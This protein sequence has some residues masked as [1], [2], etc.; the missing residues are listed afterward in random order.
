MS[1]RVLV[2][3]R[4][5][6]FLEPLSTALR[7]ADLEAAA[8]GTGQEALATL[9]ALSPVGVVVDLMTLDTEATQLCEQIRSRENTSA[10][11][12]LFVGTGAE[13]IRST[14]DALIAGGDGFFQ[15]PLEAHR[16]VAKIAAYVGVPVPAVDDALMLTDGSDGGNAPEPTKVGLPA[17][18]AL[19]DVSHVSDHHILLRSD[20][21]PGAP[22]TPPTTRRRAIED[23]DGDGDG[24]GQGD[25]DESSSRALTAPVPSQDVLPDTDPKRGRDNPQSEEGSFSGE[26]TASLR[27]GGF[28][29]NTAAAEP[30][31]VSLPGHPTEDQPE[32]VISSLIS[33]G[34]DSAEGEATSDEIQR[35]RRAGS[36]ERRRREYEER[37]RI[38]ALER[39]RKDAE[40]RLKHAEAEARR[41]EVEEQARIEVLEK[42]RQEAEGRART[43]EEERNKKEREEQARIETLERARKDA[44]RKAQQAEEE[45][46]R[47]EREEQS[48]IAVLERARQEAEHQA[49]AAAERAAR[50]EAERASREVEERQRI[51]ALEAARQEAEQRAQD[52]AARAVELEADHKRREQEERQRMLALEQ[53]REDAE[54][55]ARVADDVRRRREEE[56]QARITAL[57]RARQDAELRAREAAE[58]AAA[59][60]DQ[61]QR[62]AQD[63]HAR[64]KA[65]EQARR[66]AEQKAQDAEERARQAQ[67]EHAQR[68]EEERSYL[69]QLQQAVREA[70]QKA[71]LVE[72]ERTRRE[73]QERLR[74][75]EL[76]ASQVE[77]ET[78]LAEEETARREREVAERA[79]LEDLTRKR[80][81]VE[82][83]VAQLT[84]EAQER[85]ARARTSLAELEIARIHAEQ[86][87]NRVDEELRDREAAARAA[88]QALAQQRTAL[89]EEARREARALRERSASEEERIRALAEERAAR[90]RE[91]QEADADRRARVAEEEARLA[92]LID[93]RE[94]ERT[95]IEAELV[96]VRDDIARREADS[97]A[98]LQRMRLERKALEDE[99][100]RETEQLV[101]LRAEEE[102]TRAALIEQRARARLAF[103]SGRL[104]A[105]P[106]GV[107]VGGVDVGATR[108]PITD[109]GG[110][111]LGGP[112]LAL[113]NE[114]SGEPPAPLPFVA[115]EPLEARFGDGELPAALLSAHQ[116][117]ITG[118][119]VITHDDGRTRTLFFEQGEP[120]LLSSDLA[121]DRCEEA[122][123]RGGL[124][125]AARYNE[126]RAG[127]RLSAR[128][129]CAALVEDG[130]LKTEELFVAVRGVLTEQVLALLEWDHGTFRFVEE[131]AHATDRVRLEH[132][133]DAIVAEGLRRKYDEERLWSVLGGPAS[134]VGGDDKHR[135]LPPMSPEETMALSRFDGTRSF[136]D[137]IAETG[138]PAPV[139]LRAAL[140]AIACGAGRLLARGLPTMLEDRLLR[141]ERSVAIDRARILDRLHAA[142]QGHYFSFLGLTSDATAFEVQR[143]AEQMR[144]RFDPARYSDAAFADVR[145]ALAEICEVAR[146]AE[147]V[148]G[149]NRLREAYRANLSL[150]APDRARRRA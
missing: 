52:A 81:E 28:S 97:A 65:L 50:L 144:Q 71:H 36:E 102:A 78:R 4:R 76:R 140:L 141:R 105:V 120:V 59:L 149:D 1:A 24:D 66:D 30:V 75:A 49:Q 17:Y 113:Q 15:L 5:V 101:R 7:S 21:G 73:A 39:A 37:A 18:T 139:V 83:A 86:E 11:P 114:P 38:D 67:A 143:A 16:I 79:R 93:K 33:R 110:V 109:A 95:R 121:V 128:R 29:D 117:Q 100:A 99:A 106:P 82:A 125:T 61:Y 145:A 42:A 91:I 80:N 135:A 150:Q 62:Q 68:Q 10:V 51:A 133:L 48:R 118:V 13:S 122:L 25:E 147:A 60:E 138:L 124:I 6:A 126:L 89:E 56:E 84:K 77:L 22:H 107:D 92:A 70:Q 35:L 87:R 127:P 58:L 23:G 57:E 31:G 98:E 123:L 32:G 103:Q 108:R 88:L 40:Q 12:V 63:E 55:R 19:S 132:R 115:M 9:D 34:P 69:E 53:A 27:L 46:G 85:E 3:T 44:E 134:I 148:L 96:A 137:V 136:E 116:L 130:A 26:E 111:P 146:D 74:L 72:E 47:I 43:A 2:V 142:R 54:E 64:L 119:L 14:T 112:L 8:A 20:D 41:I 90:E 45:R 94:A 129:I 104:D 131:R